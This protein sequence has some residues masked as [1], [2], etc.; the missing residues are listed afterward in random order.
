MRFRYLLFLAVFL[1]SL[2]GFT[3]AQ[4]ILWSRTYG[5]SSWDWS[6]S[7][8]QTADGG[9]ILTGVTTSF[10][11][12]SEDVYL[13]KTDSLGNT[14]WSR[15]YGGDYWD[16][17]W[18][19][20]Q[21]TDGGYIVAGATMSFGLAVGLRYDVYL[22][23]TDSLGDTLWSRAY[24][25]S[26]GDVGRSVQQTA[27]GGYIIV[28]TT[29]SFSDELNPDDIYL[30]KTDS[31]GDTLWSRTYGGSSG[32]YGVS[33][34]Q[35]TDGGY[36]VTGET[37]SFGNAG[38]FYLI[39]TDSLGD[40]LWSRT[41]G[42]ET[43]DDG[44]CIQQTTDGGYIV[45]G[46]TEQPP[47]DI[48][49]SDVYLI[50]TDSLGD[51]LWS[52]TYGGSSFDVGRSVQQTTD[53]GYIVT[54]HTESED[55]SPIYT[56]TL[57]KLDS[58]GNACI[59]EFVTSTVSSPFCIITYPSTAVTSP[60]S[61]ITDCTTEVTSPPTQVTNVCETT[62][63]K[64]DVSDNQVNIQSVDIIKLY[65]NYPNPFN[66]ETKIKYNLSQ[67]TWVNLTIYNILGQKVK[68]LTNELQTTGMKSVTW[69]GKD[70][71]GRT[72]SSG[73]YVYKLRIDKQVVSKKMLL[74]K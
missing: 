47:Y 73:I 58:L 43:S 46:S 37:N 24:G 1:V 25:G 61:V 40:T 15:T 2:P 64:E 33:V 22:I 35:T 70:N 11:G 57:T 4:N 55:P 38:D 18:S 51:T 6:N 12:S 23:K 8:Q 28:G 39:K 16:K 67:P 34:Q 17:G 20:Q 69:D 65:Q 66:L 30:I 52:R 3:Q 68:V 14:L 48:F 27:D 9:Y 21:T 74:L 31:L 44:R 59:G 36:I 50:K 72:V 41:Y 26:E 71:S 19:V 32:D 29:S 42:Y 10:G 7:V 62:S 56:I 63:I 60:S 5:G 13:I 53:G 54:G 45:T 49:D